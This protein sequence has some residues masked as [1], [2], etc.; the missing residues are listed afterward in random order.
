MSPP[1]VSPVPVFDDLHKVGSKDSGFVT[2]RRSGSVVTVG[3]D[4]VPGD[5]TE[6]DVGLAVAE[7]G[8]LIQLLTEAKAD[9]ETY[10]QFWGDKAG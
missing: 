9:A 8:E 5:G 1:R 6:V 10:R 3:V 2:V 7:V 4:E